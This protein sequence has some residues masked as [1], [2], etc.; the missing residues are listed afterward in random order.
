[1]DAR[2]SERHLQAFYDVADA[3]AGAVTSD[4][5]KLGAIA[6]PCARQAAPAAA[7]VDAFLDGFA[8]RA[9][10]RPL[11]VEERARYQ[12]LNNGARDGRELYRSLVFSL[13]M[14]PQFLYHAELSGSPIAGSEKN[15]TL[16]PYE[17]AARLSYHF[18]QSMPDAE[19]LRVAKD[20]TIISEAGY[21]AQ[22]KRVFADARTQKTAATFYAE[23]FQVGLI[24]EFRR[25]KA[26][27]TFAAS[28]G[29]TD[30]ATGTAFLKAA[31]DEITAMTAH[32]TWTAG[33][34]FRDLLLTDLS[35]T[36]SEALGRLYGVAPWD[37]TTA[38]PTLPRSERAGLLT[39]ASFLISATHTTDP[40]HRGSVVRRRLL[41]DTLAA[42]DAASLPA[43]SLL[44]P[45]PD[46]T[47]TTRQRFT[48][49]VANEPCAS[50]HKLMNP[51]GY[52]L[53]RYDALGRYRQAEQIFDEATGKKVATLPID[54]AAVP[55]IIAGDDA[56][57]STGLELSQQ[58]ADSGR[59]EAC[60]ARQYF[61]FTYHREEAAEDDCALEGI[62]TAL[63]RGK[64]SESLLA[65]AMSRGFRTRKAQ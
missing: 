12:A 52:V 65:V 17:L 33:G 1:M 9:Y 64:L 42:P 53:E 60:F 16:S 7:C 39:R 34:T 32:F 37:G 23:W 40:I 5:A 8:L 62:R 11:T 29:I 50:C 10:R 46:P 28:S 22:V 2:F 21:A 18:W 30:T 43:D 38:Q 4:D 47:Q 61:R 41:C 51:I 44:P 13:L 27:D 20:G 58:V 6:T 55:H 31:A 19:L 48:A 57:I 59:V 25:S 35:F 14:A 26:F 54:S 3:I 15:L 63:A 56:S 36:R 49:K 24:S 45:P